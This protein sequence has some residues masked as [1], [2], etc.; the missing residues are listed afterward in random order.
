MD[1]KDE[2]HIHNGILLGHKKEQ[3]NGMCT[4]MDGPSNCHIECSKSDK[5]K[6]NMI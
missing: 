6:Y 4:N 2:V 3:N 1:K 5:D